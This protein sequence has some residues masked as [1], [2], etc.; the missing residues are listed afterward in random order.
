MKQKEMRLVIGKRFKKIDRLYRKIINGFDMELIHE[1]RTE[2]KKLRAFLRLINV[3]IG[4]NNRLRISKKIKTFY[5]YAGTIRNLQLQTESINLYIGKPEY[6]VIEA[7]VEYLDNIIGKWKQHAIEFTATK[8]NFYTRR[9]KIL[10]QLPKKFSNSSAKK[11]L[12][13]KQG[14]LMCLMMELPDDDVLH[15]IRKVLKDILYNWPFIKQYGKLPGS[16]SKKQEIKLFTDLLGLFL[17]KRIGII[18]LETYCKDCEENG[19]FFENEI[20]QFQKIE[21]LWENE[22]QQ[23]SGFIYLKTGL[24][25]LPADS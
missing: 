20:N 14:E 23:L 11:F 15:S 16:F 8:S 9:K 1:F 25:Q 12:R 5:G 2:V 19:I 3:E 4:D 6:T 17:D 22:K 21:S 13:N 7:Y 10:K 18:L 24:M